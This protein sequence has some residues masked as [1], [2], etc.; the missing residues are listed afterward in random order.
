MKLLAIVLFVAA[1]FGQ[2]STIPAAEKVPRSMM[3]WI[4]F[5]ATTALVIF[6]TGAVDVVADHVA[7]P[8]H[9][10]I[11]VWS[12]ELLPPVVARSP[13]VRISLPTMFM[14]FSLN[15]RIPKVDI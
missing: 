1:A 10:E 11:P 8:V 5:R 9:K 15:A 13:I 12:R 14:A 6:P 2:F 7:L 3:S 4:R